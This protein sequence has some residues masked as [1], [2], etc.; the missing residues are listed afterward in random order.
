M[1]NATNMMKIIRTMNVIFTNTLLITE[2]ILAGGSYDMAP[3]FG[4]SVDSGGYSNFSW[5]WVSNATY[6]SYTYIGAELFAERGI[7]NIGYIP[8]Y[9][10]I[11]FFTNK[12]TGREL[13][14][15]GDNSYVQYYQ[16]LD[17]S[18]FIWEYEAGMYEY[19]TD[20]YERVYG[21]IE[22]LGITNAIYTA[23]ATNGF[24]VIPFLGDTGFECKGWFAGVIDWLIRFDLTEEGKGFDYY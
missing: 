17:A 6:I 22:A 16:E 8:Q 23:F 10:M 12:Y 18:T 1:C 11:R 24:E 3:T 19:P 15:K 4:Y 14:A 2:N 7:V 5:G 13:Y 21:M 20:R 9:D